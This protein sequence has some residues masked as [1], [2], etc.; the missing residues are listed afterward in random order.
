MKNIILTFY[1]RII[2]FFK[3]SNNKSSFYLVIILIT[4][5]TILLSL[6]IVGKTY[7]YNI[8][9]IALSDI[10]VPWDIEYTINSQTEFEKMRAQETVSLVFDMNKTVLDEKTKQVNLLFNYIKNYLT[11][12]SYLADD[13]NYKVSM[14]LESLPDNMQYDA[15]ALSAF[16]SY[17]NPEILRKVVIE[18]L[19]EIYSNGVLEDKYDNPLGIQNNNVSIRTVSL[20]YEFVEERKKLESI[21]TVEEVNKTLL[22]RFSKLVEKFPT[23]QRNALLV[24][25][26]SLVVQN[27]RFNAEETKK[28]LA[29]ASESV[30]PVVGKLKKGQVIVREGDAITTLTF[31]VIK[32]LNEHSS[33]FHLNYLFGI[34]LYQFVFLIIFAI[35]FTDIRKS[36]NPDNKAP[37][38]ITLLLVMFFIYTYIIYQTTSMQDDKIVFS[39]LLPI[40]FIT[41]MLAILYNVPMA[42]LIGSYAIFFSVTI[43]GANYATLTIA[44]SSS[45]V[46]IFGTKDIEKR[47]DFIKSGFI[48][49]LVN[50]LLIIAISLMEELSAAVILQN[51]RLAFISGIGNCIAVMGLFPIFESLFS[52][53]TRFKLLELADLNAPI[54]KRM[55]IKAPG[56][57]NHSIMVANLAE[58]A[59]KELNT[60]Y[61]LARVGSY[62]HDIGKIDNP[63]LYIENK[64]DNAKINLN[65]LDYC[66][67]IISH[68]EKGIQIAK[69]NKI[70]QSVIDFIQEHHGDS[71]MV[72][73]YHQA[74]EEA[75]KYGDVTVNPDD[76]KYPGPKP[77]SKE[78]A[79][80]MLAD[81]VEAASRSVKEP[82]YVKLET[83]VK[84]LIYNK[85]NDGDLEY[86]DL[87][88]RDLNN[89]QKAF[90]RVL[91]GIFHTRIEYPDKEDIKDL[92]NKNK[93]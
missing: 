29:K 87:T 40:P 26:K 39:L 72:Y 81:A 75:Q 12:A 53:T 3:N 19:N 8:G 7:N 89:I 76:F 46:S 60:D 48:L 74:L 42:L 20:D 4:T 54:F 37:L 83:M 70:P 35:F 32:V 30:K 23:A 91:N 24:I 77:R 28:R 22:I 9:D 61:L 88:M 21:K 49:S 56:T 2:E 27:M 57:Y 11:S 6:N 43:S 80:V 5:S 92:E 78:T 16:I 13:N 52:L 85:L 44:I 71:L 59:C 47:I 93:E 64:S 25:T 15:A 69:E 50:S 90:L 66:K 10:R 34:F 84:K 86:S 82:T 41:M 18:I 14:L 58:T 62:Y 38:I 79:I 73:F 31:E 1:E 68:V 45:L 51:I 33:K 17:E 55:L 67:K 36:V 65:P 63:R